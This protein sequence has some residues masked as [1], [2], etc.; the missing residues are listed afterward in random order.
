[1]WYNE[2]LD[3][4][5]HFHEDAKN[6]YSENERKRNDIK[7]LWLGNICIIKIKYIKIKYNHFLK[8]LQVIFS[9]AFFKQKG[10]KFLYRLGM[11]RCLWV[12]V[13]FP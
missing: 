2:F 3:G 9:A 4:L 11:F 6:L 5:Y 8:Y 10:M 1:M 13:C 12:V 7:I